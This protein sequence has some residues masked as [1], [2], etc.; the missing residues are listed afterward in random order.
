MGWDQVDRRVRR[1]GQLR[2][3][4]ALP[5]SLQA[6]G[7]PQMLAQGIRSGWWVKSGIPSHVCRAASAA[8]PS[9]VARGRG[10]VV[11]SQVKSVRTASFR[12][13]LAEWLGGQTGRPKGIWRLP[14]FRSG[15]LRCC[16]FLGAGE[17]LQCCPACISS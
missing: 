11:H 8:Y 5:S 16:C 2:W 14:A 1:L 9:G 17:R 7:L 15:A 13:A 4:A 12:L 6:A 10:E 3:L